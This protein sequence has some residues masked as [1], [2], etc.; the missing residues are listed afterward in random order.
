MELPGMMRVGRDHDGGYVLPRDVI[1][2]S[3]TLLSLGVNDDWS[4]EEAA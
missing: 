4:F 3:H 1:E 2:R